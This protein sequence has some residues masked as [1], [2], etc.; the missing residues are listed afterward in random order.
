METKDV[1]RQ[2]AL[3]AAAGVAGTLV[4]RA[5]MAANKK[6][7]PQT[8]QPLEEDP[9]QHVIQSLEGMLPQEIRDKIPKSLEAVG[10]HFLSFGYGSTGAALYTAMRSDPSLLLDGAVLGAALWAAGYAGWLP[11]MGLTPQVRKN[12]PAQ[13]ASS[14]FQHIAYGVA[15]VGAYRKLRSSAVSA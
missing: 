6:L 4:I 3:G 2:V 10:K 7:A 1:L 9:G 13:I 12:Q 14:I 11:A 8:M 5:V 15:T